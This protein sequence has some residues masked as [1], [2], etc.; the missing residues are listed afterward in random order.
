MNHER[1]VR[2][3]LSFARPLTRL[4]ELARRVRVG[5][6]ILRARVTSTESRY[7]LELRGTERHLERALRAFAR[8]A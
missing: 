3:E 2:L 5:L 7:E 4:E 6:R 8:P 1:A